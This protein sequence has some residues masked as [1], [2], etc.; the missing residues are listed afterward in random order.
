MK[1][2]LCCYLRSIPMK[3]LRK[4]FWMRR[5][6]LQ[7]WGLIGKR[8]TNPKCGIWIMGL[9]ITW[10]G[11]KNK[12]C[13]I[14]YKV[15]GYVRFGDGSRVRIEGKRAIL[16]QCKN[17]EQRL[18]REVYYILSLC[19][20]I[21]SLGQLA[22]G[23]DKIVLLGDFLWVHDHSGRLLMEVKRSPNRLYKIILNEVEGKCLLGEQCEENWL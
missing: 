15:K 16:F 3:L 9:V 14:D 1:N 21:I 20:N 6:S 7:S 2:L 22:E 18:L 17:G 11:K 10:Q 19:S 23:G 13:E 4:Y 5:E 8:Q 12:F